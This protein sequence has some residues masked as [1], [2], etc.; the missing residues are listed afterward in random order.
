METFKII[1]LLIIVSDLLLSCNTVKQFNDCHCFSKQE[2]INAIES[3]A[4]DKKPQFPG[5]DSELL[6]YVA[7][8]GNY[9]PTDSLDELQSSFYARFVIDTCGKVKNVCILRPLYSDR[10]TGPEK[11]FLRIIS[12]M[13]V[14]IPAENKGKKVPV[15]FIMPL[16]IHWQ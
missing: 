8:H 2:K 5:G 4:V 10:L 6:R 15:W 11:E 14:W 7:E 1:N 13:P 16:K 9:L 3:F 12:E